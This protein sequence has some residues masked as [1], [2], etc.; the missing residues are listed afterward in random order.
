MINPW[1]DTC[2]YQVDADSVKKYGKEK[3]VVCVL[4]EMTW[5]GFSN[6][7]VQK[8]VKSWC[9]FLYNAILSLILF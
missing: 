2:G 4:W 8:K 3:F 1:N 9:H 5:L 6:E 7:K